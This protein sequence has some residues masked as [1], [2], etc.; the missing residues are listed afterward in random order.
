M[1]IEPLDGTDIELQKIR[2]FR[3]TREDLMRRLLHDFVPESCDEWDE[4]SAGGYVLEQRLLQEQGWT[5]INTD[6]IR[7]SKERKSLKGRSGQ[8]WV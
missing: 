8:L 3:P 1:D 4:A 5:G 6:P 2:A 7:P